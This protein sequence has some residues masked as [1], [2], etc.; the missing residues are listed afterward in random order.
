MDSNTSLIERGFKY[1]AR[2]EGGALFAYKYKPEKRMRV[3]VVSEDA[4]DSEHPH[5]TQVNDGLCVYDTIQWEDKEPT[6]IE[7]LKSAVRQPLV[8]PIEFGGLS[9][10]EQKGGG[11][12]I[13]KSDLYKEVLDQNAE[14]RKER[15]NELTGEKISEESSDE[16]EEEPDDSPD[17]APLAVV[18]GPDD[19]N[20]SIYTPVTQTVDNVNHP[21]HYKHGEIET[22]DIIRMSL[23]A[24]EFHGFLKGNVLK[25]QIRAPHKHETPDEDYKKAKFYYD[26]LQEVEDNA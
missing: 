5:Y 3:W 14:K 25:Y 26:R 18:E 15:F 13:I 17:D 8:N 2:D 11:T 21:Q 19:S 24:E 22:L 4:E 16:P 7:T 6:E 10:H 1:L 12:Y 20:R 9:I 23:T